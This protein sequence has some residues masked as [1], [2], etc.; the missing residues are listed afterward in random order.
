MFISAVATNIITMIKKQSVL[1]G[2]LLMSFLFAFPTYAATSVAN[3]DPLSGILSV[4]GS[5]SG[6]Y[7]LVVI[8]NSAS[9][10]VWGSSNPACVAGSYRYQIAIP[11]NL[12][13]GGAFTVSAADN[14]AAATGGGP[15]S[16]VMFSPPP[17][18]L[19][20]QIMAS[21]SISL[22]LDTS[23]LNV[24]GSDV[25]FL[26]GILQS[27]F[28]IVGSAV[29]AVESSVVAAV[30]LFAKVFTILPGGS[31]T[32]PNG[33]NQ[34]SG[35]GTLATGDTEV[36]IANTA[37]T[38]SSDIIVTPTTPS[39]LPLAVMQ[40]VP[41]SGFD[42][43][44][45][46]PQTIPTSFNWLIVGTYAVGSST[47]QGAGQSGGGP[48]PFLAL[49]LSVVTSGTSSPDL[50]TIS[51]S[52][53]VSDGS[54]SGTSPVVSAPVLPASS[55]TASIGDTSSS[56][57]VNIPLII[58]SSSDISDTTP[59]IA[60]SADSTGSA[61][62]SAVTM[63]SPPTS[64]STTVGSAST[65]TAA[66]VVTSSPSVPSTVVPAPTSSSVVSVSDPVPSSSLD[67]VS[68]PAPL[69]LV[70]AS[71]SAPEASS[72]NATGTVQ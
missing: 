62:S 67:A 53:T 54:A 41:G 71:S 13:T 40:I 47:P 33:A 28:G 39:Q 4:T 66:S 44:V 45:L 8:R 25:S 60:P 19:Q 7:V 31:L 23:S 6:R 51:A 15:A 11:E 24:G 50:G 70:S 46:S 21:G 27:L 30:Q 65:N 48:S 1:F 72:T 32:V 17:P 10:A 69:P 43:G 26:D 12:R 22:S 57:S 42:V 63:V 9:G 49:P 59:A 38:S 36:F 52:S 14:G 64:A 37:V 34:I 56:A 35:S 16:P 5:C 2:L 58:A 61:G 29:N 18:E 68:A 20:Q 55:S 3:F